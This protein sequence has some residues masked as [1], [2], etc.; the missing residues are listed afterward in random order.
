M[1]VFLI[2]VFEGLGSL[3]RYGRL[4]GLRNRFGIRSNKLIIN[5]K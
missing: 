2:E 3:G 1:D 4:E 5:N